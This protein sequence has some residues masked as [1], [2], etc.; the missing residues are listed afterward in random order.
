MDATTLQRARRL[1][2]QSGRDAP[3]E[4]EEVT[5]AQLGT[6]HARVAYG[7]APFVDMGVCT[8][9]EGHRPSAERWAVEVH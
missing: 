7:L 8:S 2:A 3:L 4:K 5:D 1:L 6:L 9:N